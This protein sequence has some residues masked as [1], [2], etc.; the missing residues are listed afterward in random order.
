MLEV[1]SLVKRPLVRLTT[2]MRLGE[3]SL[4]VCIYSLGVDGMRWTMV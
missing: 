2:E 4:A 1:R 3:I